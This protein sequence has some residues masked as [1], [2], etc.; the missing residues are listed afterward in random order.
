MPRLKYT[1]PSSKV[2]QHMPPQPRTLL[3]RYLAYR[4]S[5]SAASTVMRARSTVVR[6]ACY[7]GERGG[8]LHTAEPSDAYDFISE[9]AWSAGTKRQ[10]ISDLR[11]LY[12]WMLDQDLCTRN[13][14]RN[15]K[16]PLMPKRIPRVLTSAE[17]DRIDAATHRPTV[18]DLRDRALLAFL[19]GS[20][21]RIGEARSLDMPDVDFTERQAIVR[22]K[23]YKE[24][25]VFF[26]DGASEALRVWIDCGRSVWARS[27]SGA[28]FLGRH[29][30]RICYTACRD[31][32][33]RA[34]QRAGLS[35]HVRCHIYRHTWA[36][37]L[38]RNGADL[39]EVQVLMGHENI[40][41]TTIYT[42]V[43]QERL[44]EVYD[45]SH[46]PAPR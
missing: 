33:I 12:E 2:I 6:W 23:R 45:R 14:W 13:P 11:A 21:C 36:T 42:H 27:Q 1:T 19:R 44:R 43:A 41:T 40:S 26:D 9:W 20:G 8:E 10:A 18:R 38:L 25:I 46:E 5:N 29:G 3:Q 7:L 16:G 17:M 37:D 34:E 28:V 15:V 24:R 30:D 35:R 4:R 32:L 31:A 22:G 39:R